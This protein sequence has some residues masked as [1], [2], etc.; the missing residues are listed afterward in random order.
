MNPPHTDTRSFLPWPAGTSFV[1]TKNLT[2][3]QL[4]AWNHRVWRVT[5]VEELQP[6]GRRPWRLVLGNPTSVNRDE[7]SLGV[8]HHPS[9]IHAFTEDE[10]YPVCAN[11]GGPWPCRELHSREQAKQDAARARRYELPGVCPACEEPVTPRQL[12]QTWLVN[13][14]HWDRD[15]PV[16]FHLRRGCEDEAIRYDR[17]VRDAGMPSQLGYPHERG[18]SR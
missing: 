5:S 4:V 2:P 16:T 6:G 13:L 17:E 10:H 14:H 8:G 12:R 3:G 7:V 15:Q 18:T 9:H 11:C 1:S